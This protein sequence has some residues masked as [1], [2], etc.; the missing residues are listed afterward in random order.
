MKKIREFINKEKL[1]FYLLSFIIIVNAA[2]MVMSIG[3]EEAVEEKIN[4]KEFELQ[5]EEFQRLVEEGNPYAIGLG[6]FMMLAF[7]GFTIGLVLF[8]RFIYA[9]LRKREIGIE[10]LDNVTKTNWGIFSCIRV[11][12]LFLWFG[13]ILHFVEGA[14]F[15]LLNITDPPKELLMM[16]NAAIMDVLAFFFVVYFLVEQYGKRLREVGLSLKNITRKIGLGIV[17]YL[18]ALPALLAVILIVLGVAKLVN[19][20]PEPQKIFEIFYSPISKRLL[21]FST[22]FVA[23]GGPI[24]EEVFF[25]GFFYPALK[26]ITNAPVG[27][28]LSSGIFA[29]LHSNIVGFFP[30]MALGVLLAWLYERTGSL[31]PSMVAHII[32][33][34]AIVI[35]V[36]LTR[37]LV[38]K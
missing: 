36:L 35:V 32:H 19:Y 21:I 27:I 25:R 22:L 24:A 5:P 38:M 33:N 9:K 29:L 30:I 17:S 10:R 13:Y 26:K 16:F 8:F 4:L 12:I 7:F 2:M 15:T 6:S 20:E 1:Y 11:V 23:I 37:E 18:T 28:L 31:I 3:K 34:T 14:I